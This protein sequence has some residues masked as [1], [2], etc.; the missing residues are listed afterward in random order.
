MLLFAVVGRRCCEY[1]TVAR[2]AY[3]ASTFGQSPYSKN[4]ESVG[5]WWL[6]H[7]L[8]FFKRFLKIFQK[9]EQFETLRYFSRFEK[10]T[11][12]IHMLKLE[13]KLSIKSKGGRYAPRDPRLDRDSARAFAR[14]TF[15]AKLS[16]A[17]NSRSFVVEF[18]KG[19][20]SHF[21]RN[22]LSLSLCFGKTASF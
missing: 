4:R 21:L 20:R 10:E 14:D 5:A 9:K 22:S 17:S 7:T 13:K 6:F 12:E 3:S 1:G 19:P 2:G 16:N 18:Q 15:F 8:H 11:L